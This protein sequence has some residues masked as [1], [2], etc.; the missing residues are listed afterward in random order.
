VATKVPFICGTR[1]GRLVIT[2][3][4][5]PLCVMF[6][7]GLAVNNAFPLANQ[8]MINR[9]TNSISIFLTYIFLPLAQH[10]QRS[11]TETWM[12]SKL[13]QYVSFIEDGDGGLLGGP[14]L[15]MLSAAHVTF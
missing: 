2:Y 8:A 11:A 9:E 13:S 6:G 1:L 12:R 5:S 15:E 3:A 14:V 7:S 10:P 4:P